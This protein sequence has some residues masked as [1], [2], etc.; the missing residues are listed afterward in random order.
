MHIVKD[1][2]VHRCRDIR[3]DGYKN[4]LTADWLLFVTAA[5]NNIGY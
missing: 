4:R 5:F 3:I 1:M 2:V